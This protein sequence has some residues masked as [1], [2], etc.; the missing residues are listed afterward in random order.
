MSFVP[1]AV[2]ATLIGAALVAAPAAAQRNKKADAAA[3]E[4][5]A[6][7]FNQKNL[8]KAGRT[9]VLAA[10]NLEKAG[11]LPGAVASI[12]AAEAA[13]GLNPTDQLYLAQAKL[14]LGQKLKDD[15]AIEEALK[16]S[17]A[18]PLLPASQRN[19]YFRVLGS[20]AIQRKDY[21]AG[22]QYYTQLAEID[23]SDA[24]V[25]LSLA[26][27]YRD[28]K[29]NPQA[30]AAIDRAVAAQKAKGVK[31]SEDLYRTSLRIAYDAKLAP[32]LSAASMT[33]VREYPNAVNWNLALSLLNDATND[34]QLK[35]DIFRLM[36]ATDSLNPE[37]YWLEYS[38]IALDKGLP[39]EAV[40]VLNE[41]KAKKMLN[42]TKPIEREIA[43]AA[44]KMV[45]ADRAALPGLE[46]DA[47]KAPTGKGALA[48]GDAYFGFGNY[49]K[50][51]ELYRLA[52]TKSTGAD[53][54]TANLRLGAALAMAKDKAGATTAFQA[55]QGGARA[56][57]AQY[58]LTYLGQTA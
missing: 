37:G 24:D 6:G 38:R 39:G 20:Q 26:Q 31:P 19:Q 49:A 45:A 18:N 25:Q 1:R 11:D 55:V 9:A 36:R 32:Q 8:S 12:R 4:A 46:R 52:A 7:P 48:T 33:L 27:I 53:A 40:A 21:Q 35:L 30:L 42:G 15:K 50:A 28:L 10:Q 58:W 51:A 34:D 44:G 17:V 23:P 5:A 41:G 13:G 22:T 2:A 29:Q 54:E 56:N 14:G 16:S 47:A 57:L 43:A 3:A